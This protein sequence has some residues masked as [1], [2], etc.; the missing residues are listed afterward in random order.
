MSNLIFPLPLLAKVQPQSSEPSGALAT[1][2]ALA[3]SPASPGESAQPVMPLPAQPAPAPPPLRPCPRCSVK[4]CVFPAPSDEQTKCRYHQLLQSEGELFQSQQPSHLLAL[5]APFGIP[6][7]EPDD[8]RYKD[9]E[10]QAAEREEFLLDEA[11]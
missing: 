1:Q 4:G 7:C 9:R 5:H 10:R 3:P 8:S 11:A 2:R 6:D